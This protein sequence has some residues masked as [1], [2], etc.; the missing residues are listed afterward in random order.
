MQGVVEERHRVSGRFF[1]PRLH[2]KGGHAPRAHDVLL[3]QLAVRAHLAEAVVHPKMNKV[4]A[5]KAVTVC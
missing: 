5:E 3:P 1:G 2:G 4:V